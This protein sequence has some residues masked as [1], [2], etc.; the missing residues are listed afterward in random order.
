ML[1]HLRTAGLAGV[2]A[3]VLA[4]SAQAEDKAPTAAPPTAAPAAAPAADCGAPAADCCAPQYRTVCVT[5]WKAEQYQSTR[6]CYRTETKQETYTAYR[7]ECVPETRTRTC[8]VYKM[9]PEVHTETRTVCVR[10]PVCEERTVMKSYVTCKPVVHTVRK[11]VDQGHYECREVCCKPSLHDRLHKLCHHN[12]CCESCA[13]PTKTV[14]VWV[15]CPVWVETPVTCYERVCEQRP[16]TCKVTTWKTEQRQESCQVTCCKCVPE[17]KTETY[18][19]MV[20]HQ[21][22]YQATRCVCVSVPY[23]E[24][25]TLCRMVPHTV[26]KQVPVEQCCASTCGHHKH[27]HGH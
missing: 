8:T 25:V 19:V 24:T 12:D 21:V 18:Q 15:P 20:A 16:V 9:V 13:P 22:P 17:V 5:E 7:C 14:R 1:K 11:C 6:T 4:L 10:V 3:T 27:H 2:V 26:E 23:Q